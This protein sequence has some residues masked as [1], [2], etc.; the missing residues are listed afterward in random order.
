MVQL[1]LLLMF[2][3]LSD[4]FVSEAAVTDKTMY[5]APLGTSC[6]DFYVRCCVG[7]CKFAFVFD[8][9]P[10]YICSRQD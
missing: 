1:Q 10:V 4:S 9:K 8:N 7:Q 5:C 3:I 2:L 6:D